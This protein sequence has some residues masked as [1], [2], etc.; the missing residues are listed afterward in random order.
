[1]RF[2]RRLLR[3]DIRFDSQILLG[4]LLCSQVCSLV[5][6]FDFQEMIGA[7]ANA[8]GREVKV[9]VSPAA[10]MEPTGSSNR[11]EGRIGHLLCAIRVF[12]FCFE[13]F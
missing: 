9:F 10:I 1:M 7:V 12:N 4:S 6:E 5:W 8:L 2:V 13:L 3:L 11:P